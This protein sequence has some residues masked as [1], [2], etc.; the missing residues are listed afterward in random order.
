MSY[1]K[2]I[3][4][5]TQVIVRVKTELKILKQMLRFRYYNKFPH[6]GLSNE[7]LSIIILSL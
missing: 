1:Q 5:L 2:L 4:K 7:S 3:E 6:S